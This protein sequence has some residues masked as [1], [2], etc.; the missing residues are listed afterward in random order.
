MRALV[1]DTE[2]TDLVHNR[3]VRLDKAP[4]IIEFY[5][6][7][8]DLATGEIENEMEFL[9][10]PKNNVNEKG[11]A[12]K[13]VG[14]TNEMLKDAPSFET[15][16]PLIKLYIESAPMVIAHNVAFDKDIIDIEYER[17]KQTINWP[18]T[19]CTVEAT[20]YLQGWRMKL[21]DLHRYLFNVNFEGAHR[22]KVDVQALVK[23][24]T[25]LYRR[26]II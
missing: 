19:L 21:N 5:G 24:C 20:V 2:T 6:C 14:L 13:S 10:K 4:E 23:C 1:L 17:I 7:V 8:A 16:A 22:A 18:E 11:K 9:I 15:I 26:E 25:E 12:F 3:T